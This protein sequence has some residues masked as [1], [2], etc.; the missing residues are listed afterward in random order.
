MRP[1]LGLLSTTGLC[2]CLAGTAISQSPPTA[3]PEAP[4]AVIDWLGS[5]PASRPGGTGGPE[6]ADATEPPVAVT[7]T[8]PPITVAPLGQGQ[9]REI[10]LVP[11]NVTG[12]PTRLWY[13]SDVKE[14]VRRIERLPEL[15]LPAAQSLL[16]TLLLA[17]ALAPA[18][19]APAGDVL[20]V[21]RVAKLVSLGALDPALSLIEQ[22]GVTTSP[23]HFDLWMDIS[24]LT[25]TEDRACATLA[26]S[27]HL[28]LE[29][30]TRIFCHA[31]NGKWD[32]AALTFGSAQAL[33]LMPET[34]LALFE[35]F[36]HPD[37][38][39]G[40]PPLPAPRDMDPMRFRLYE[41]I[42]EPKSTRS[43]PRAYAVADLR[44]LAGWKSQLEAA[45][46]LTRAGA[47]PDN[48]LLGFYTAREPAASGGVWDRVEAF[49]QFET[50]LRSGRDD[51]VSETLP[52]AWAAMQHAELEMAFAS[53]F[54]D[55]LLAFD[56]TGSAKRIAFELGLLSPAYEKFAATVEEIET[57]VPN[58]ALLRAVAMGEAPSRRP[59]DDMAAAIHDAFATPEPRA[60][61]VAL[62]EN[63]QLG[64]AILHLLTLL[65][66]GA[67][68]D[69]ATL[70][71]ALSTLRALG[72]EDTARRA[73][74]QM[75]LLDRSA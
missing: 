52:D 27:P 45:E 10:G 14:V 8:P 72:L 24:L 12:L 63:D 9:P 41:T 57:L 23:A 38:F 2:L 16:Y 17:D 32:N 1:C 33:E 47:L 5:Q 21:A 60:D 18:A 74:L 50:A 4:L 59:S 22:A 69:S 66:D 58:G 54:A 42:G 36:L 7:A 48:V 67:R 55:S 46:R 6:S 73:A 62:A 3:A 25:G 20:A 11:S 13:G 43:L 29:Y 40:E 39:E 75:L 56:L 35:R 51:A 30:G 26:K 31:R 37:A 53:L 49:Q 28:T 65:E 68:G 64:L 70:R 15:H 19:E 61:L 44:D 71:S 34:A